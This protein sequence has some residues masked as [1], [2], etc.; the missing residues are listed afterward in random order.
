[1]YI[2]I[3]SIT[4]FV[5]RVSKRFESASS[6]IRTRGTVG[7]AEFRNSTRA[8]G[9]TFTYIANYVKLH[10]NEV[11]KVNSAKVILG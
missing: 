7:C 10:G 4:W 9:K 11:I 5:Q 3:V 8:N 2:K 1:M 6:L